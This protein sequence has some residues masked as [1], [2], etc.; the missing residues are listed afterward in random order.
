MHDDELTVQA[1]V[2]P[3]RPL[4][5]VAVS[6]VD[7]RARGLTAELLPGI[8]VSVGKS[9]DNQLVLDDMTVSRYHV[10]LTLRRGDIEVRDLES[11]NGTYIGETRID[12]VRVRPGTR[13]TIG[14]NT[15][16]LTAEA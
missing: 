8:P 11:M 13:L 15:I 9:P 16:L 1:L 7:G 14:L 12:R 6:V 3:S 10:E 2:R 5:R 4:S